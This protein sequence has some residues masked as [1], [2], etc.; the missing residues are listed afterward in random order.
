M[1]ASVCVSCKQEVKTVQSH[2]TKADTF[3]DTQPMTRIVF[4]FKQTDVCVTRQGGKTNS[5]QNEA[6]PQHKS[7]RCHFWIGC[8]ACEKR[9]Y[10]T[11]LA[12]PNWVKSECFLQECNQT[13]SR[14]K[15]RTVAT[16]S[17]PSNAFLNPQK[18]E[19]SGN[20][21]TLLIN[22]DR[23]ATRGPYLHIRLTLTQVLRRYKRKKKKHWAASHMNNGQ[24]VNT[25]WGIC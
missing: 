24:S 12:G 14:N 7:S 25:D 17:T 23:H 6:A 10:M 4:L 20:N 11:R 21:I 22:K 13:V 16:I 5:L 2:R 8:G 1:R 9:K 19:S 18:I 3:L 15:I